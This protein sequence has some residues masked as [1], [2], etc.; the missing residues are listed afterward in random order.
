[1]RAT[2][3]QSKRSLKFTLSTLAFSLSGLVAAEE[4]SILQGASV[5]S[6][7][8]VPDSA[9]G[10][11]IDGNYKTLQEQ[12][13]ANADGDAELSLVLP[14]SQKVVSAFV[15]NRVDDGAELDLGESAIYV[16]DDTQYLSQALQ[17]CSTDFYDTSFLQFASPC[18]GKVVSIRRKGYPST[19]EPAY[20]VAQ[21]RLY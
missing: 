4:A 13:Q 11:L 21:V 6:E 18:T 5:S 1:M 19:S 17:K 20:N 15:Q 8:N 16:G 12:K 14:K 2:T 7:G 9:A 10:L 3:T